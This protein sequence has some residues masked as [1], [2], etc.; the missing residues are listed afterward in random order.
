MLTT[1]NRYKS[2]GFAPSTIKR[3]TQ[4]TSRFFLPNQKDG[5][6]PS[7]CAI[8]KGPIM[9]YRPTKI[10]LWIAESPAKAFAELKRLYRKHGTRRAVAEATGLNHKTLTRWKDRLA[11]LGY[12]LETPPPG[13]PKSD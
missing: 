6:H 13:R 1:P 3:G 10:S 7:G 11:K 8:N 5:S 2:N 4:N 9:S 12:E